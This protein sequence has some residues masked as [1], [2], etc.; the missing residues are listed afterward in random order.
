MPIIKVLNWPCK[1]ATADDSRLEYSTLLGAIRTDNRYKERLADALRRAVVDAEIT[2]I[3]SIRGVT[4]SFDAGHVLSPKT[5]DDDKTLVI[6]VF[7][8]YDRRDRTKAVRDRLAQCLLVAAKKQVE[9]GWKV[10][11]FVTRFNPEK[12][13]MAIG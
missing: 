1:L 10:E 8:L 5:A 11:V 6:W 4:V 12:E 9:D 13:S 7:G 3:D 2:G